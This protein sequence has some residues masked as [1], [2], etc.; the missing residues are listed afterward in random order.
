MLCLF[1]SGCTKIDRERHHE[2]PLPGGR[3]YS[4]RSWR[5]LDFQG[6]ASICEVSLNGPGWQSERIGRFQVDKY[7]SSHYCGF[8]PPWRLFEF[9]SRI[10]VAAGTVVYTKKERRWEAWSPW[11]TPGVYEFMS[12]VN[13]AKVYPDALGVELRQHK[14][15][16]ILEMLLDVPSRLRLIF[17]DF[18]FDEAAT[19][20]EN[21]IR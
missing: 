15:S 1:V 20:R 5:E 13:P 9:D 19:L 7:G 8:G 14:G 11:Q 17:K 10:A 6:G 3:T 12:R 4:I 16:W 2:E 18:A 21:H